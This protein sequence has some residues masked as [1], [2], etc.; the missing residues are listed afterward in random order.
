MINR[1]H[2]IGMEVTFVGCSKEQI[3]WGGNDDPKG[4][5]K[6]GNKYIVTHIESR[7]YHTKL[8]LKG[9]KGKFN[10]VCFD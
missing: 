6:K 2:V 10:S 7:S 8:S 9:I 1:E 3:K 5:L 4:L